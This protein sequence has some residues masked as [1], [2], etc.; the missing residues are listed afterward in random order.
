[1]C[2]PSALAVLGL[3]LVQRL[4]PWR[5]RQELNDVAGYLYAVVGVVYAVL[6]ALVVIA[7]WEHREVARDNTEREANAVAEIFWLAHDLPETEG[8]QLQ[9]LARSY[10]QTVV[11]EEWPLMEQTG[12]EWT[13]MTQGASGDSESRTWELLDEIRGS[14]QGWQPTT[15][16]EQVLYSQGIDQVNDLADARRMRLVEVGEHLPVILWALVGVGGLITVG[17]TYFFGLE[18]ARAQRVMVLALAV[19]INLAI[20]TIGVL[21][22]PFA[23]SAKLRPEAFEL[24]LERFE[25]SELST[26]R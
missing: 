1:V 3:V 8:Q 11:D 20:I 23:G 19:V 21:E 17:F 26:L 24:I 4:V 13:M 6:V 18:N 22:S 2:V 5:H 25:T 15:E 9:E 14:L 10:A 12:S 7:A 16:D